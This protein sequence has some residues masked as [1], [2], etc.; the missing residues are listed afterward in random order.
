M[1]VVD[2]NICILWRVIISLVVNYFFKKI[3]KI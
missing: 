1:E 3:N 2:I